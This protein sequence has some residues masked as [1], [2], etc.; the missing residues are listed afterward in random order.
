M[1]QYISSFF[2]GVVSCFTIV[3]INHELKI[4]VNNDLTI[5][6]EHLKSNFDKIN[7]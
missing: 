1:I 7:K 5:L 3:S 4:K 2:D 6:A